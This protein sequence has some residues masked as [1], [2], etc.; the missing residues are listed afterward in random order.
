MHKIKFLK[1][2]LKKVDGFRNSMRFISKYNRK[3]SPQLEALLLSQLN[4]KWTDVEKWQ[5]YVS[6]SPFG[7][8]LK[9]FY[10]MVGFI[11]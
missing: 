6:Q 1:K 8:F 7:N 4:I 2:Y 9:I 11:W 5:I 3:I 10:G